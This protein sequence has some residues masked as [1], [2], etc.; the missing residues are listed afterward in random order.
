M[1]KTD[2]TTKY[3][4]SIR[5]LVDRGGSVLKEADARQTSDKF[6]PLVVDDKIWSVLGFLVRE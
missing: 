3:L 4:C 1:K 6:V 2:L 5:G